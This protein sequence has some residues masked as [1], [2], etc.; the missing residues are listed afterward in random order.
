MQSIRPIHVTF[1]HVMPTPE[2][3]ELLEREAEHLMARRP[4]VIFARVAVELPHR[5][6]HKAPVRVTVELGVPGRTL[7]VRARHEDQW[8]AVHAA[9]SGVDRS[10]RSYKQRRI[11]RRRARWRYRA[12]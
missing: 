3:V 8:A 11:T 7:V 10:L 9:F 2:L 6:R 12:A 5:K 1:R 4:P